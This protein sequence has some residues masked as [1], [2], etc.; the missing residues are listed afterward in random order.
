MG[1]L[2]LIS[3]VILEYSGPGLAVIAALDILGAAWTWWALRS[4]SYVK[5]LT[6]QT[7]GRYAGA[8]LSNT[9]CGSSFAIHS[10]GLIGA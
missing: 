10:G 9:T 5:G 1:R 8:T 4:D 6:P 2:G 7:T 3:F